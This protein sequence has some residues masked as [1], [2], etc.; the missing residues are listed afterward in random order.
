MALDLTLIAIPKKASFILD[1]AQKD[2][3]Y[4]M[5]LDKVQNTDALKH[6][7]KMVQAD[8][9]EKKFEKSLVE[10]IEDSEWLTN[11]YPDGKSKNYIF[12]SKTRGYD[13]LNY[14]LQQYILDNR[15]G[16]NFDKNIFHGGLD[17]D[18]AR[19]YT[20][21]EYLDAERAAQVSDLL[22]SI[23]FD[24]LLKYYDPEAMS[25]IVYKLIGPEHL[26]N[27][28][29]EFQELQQFYLSAKRIEAF[30]IIKVS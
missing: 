13:T 5:D 14:L 30:I 2:P 21:L 25:A 10:L 15:P 20:R 1:K 6:Q 23:E 19:Q 12:V 3:H 18:F 11:L 8:P 27:L 17:I 29:S 4:A 9:K 24:E 28:K 26:G 7:L 22:N 16:E